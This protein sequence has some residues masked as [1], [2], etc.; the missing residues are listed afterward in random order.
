MEVVDSVVFIFFALNTIYILVFAMTSLFRPKKRDVV[1]C[2]SKRIAVF[3]PA[4]KEDGVIKE[5]VDSL[6]AQDYPKES[7]TIVVISD[8]MTES[9]NQELADRPIKLIKAEFVKST[10]SK[11]LNLALS[12]IDQ[13]DIAVILDADNTV[14]VDFLAKIDQCFSNPKI[15]I[16][17][18]H[19]TAKNLNNKLSYLDAVSEEINNTIFRQ[20]HSNIGLSASFIGSG[21]AFDFD[22]FKREMSQIDA[23]GGFDRHLMLTL[24]KQGLFVHYLSDV[25]VYDEKVQNADTFSNQRKRWLS[26]QLHYV[27]VYIKDLPG[28]ILK[29]NIDFVD[30]YVQQ[31]VLP[32]VLL[33][34]L[35]F[36]IA[37]AM[38]LINPVLSIK[39]WMLCGV[40]CFALIVSIP[41]KL[42]TF[43]L[44]SAVLVLPEAFLRMFV[45]LFKLKGANKNFIHTPHGANKTE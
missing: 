21:M 32:R 39:W 24:L 37:L 38:V 27:G 31:L 36:L 19:R 15:Q 4:Y 9:T 25:P 40:I 22:L 3:V 12:N 18:A 6:L 10:K 23:I 29:G 16:V 17:Q 34:G 14:E 41:K 2:S 43:R 45:N 33:A 20:G 30:M 11:A 28:A 26:A 8:H 13:H 42:L 44:L 1:V 7:Y 35:V 5:C